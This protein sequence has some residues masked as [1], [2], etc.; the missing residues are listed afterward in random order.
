MYCRCI[1]DMFSSPWKETH[2]NIILFFSFANS[3]TKNVRTFANLLK[4]IGLQKKVIFC[5]ALVKLCTGQLFAV[6]YKTVLCSN[7]Q[8]SYVQ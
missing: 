8:N 5:G 4:Q 1:C 7:V 3:Y 2:P 6:M